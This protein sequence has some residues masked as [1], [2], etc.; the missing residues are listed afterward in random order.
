[1][2]PRATT[3][4]RA[5][6][7][8][9]L[10]IIEEPD[11]V[12][13]RAEALGRG[14]VFEAR[15]GFQALMAEALVRRLET[16]AKAAAPKEWFGLAIVQRC[17]DDRGNYALVLGVV[18]DTDARTAPASVTTTAES[19]F[20]TRHSARILY[21]DG[22]PGGWAHS[23]PGYGVAFSQQDRRNQATW[24][25]PD[26]LGIVVDPWAEA[27]VGVYRGPR[28]ERLRLV[29]A[30]SSVGGHCGSPE[31]APAHAASAEAE[32]VRRIRLIE[33]AGAIVATILLAVGVAASFWASLRAY[34]TAD[35]ARASMGGLAR[36][37]DSL[38]D[39][40][41][42]MARDQAS[43]SELDTARERT[44]VKEHALDGGAADS[45]PSDSSVMESSILVGRAVPVAP[46]HRWK[47]TPSRRLQPAPEAGPD[48]T[49][50]ASDADAPRTDA[51]A[52][53]DAL[54]SQST[55]RQ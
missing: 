55:G 52:G 13:P 21:P 2:I 38:E 23:H 27:T 43:S 17:R 53:S 45:T 48:A 15:D 51:F 31:A 50:D 39:A 54:D 12:L 24:T 37:I 14:W 16:W 42:F 6:T 49:M 36:R 28:S 1:M 20:R 11:R 4:R 46:T 32:G 30:T 25:E 29:T 3:E 22:V 41:A 18:P 5:P 9:P 35:A 34:Q 10:P 19:E 33:R 26:S 47:R 7:F 44:C 8:R 40:H